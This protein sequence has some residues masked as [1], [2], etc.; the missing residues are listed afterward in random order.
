MLG[1]GLP[2]TAVPRGSVR[3]VK[4][5][6]GGSWPAVSVVLP[7]LNEEHHLRTSVG[8]ILGQSYPG[9][10]EVVIALGPSKD[11]T[12]VVANDLAADPRI[13]IV[14]NPTGR[15]PNG[16]NAAIA[17][18]RHPVIAR[19]DGHAVIPPDYLRTAVALLERTGADNVGGLMSAHGVTDIEQAVAWAMTSKLGVGNAPF[20]VGGHEGPADTVYLGVFRRTALDRVG[21]YDETFKRAQD[22]EMNFR[23]RATG[24]LVWFSPELSVSYRPRGSLKAVAKQYFHY[25]RWRRHVMRTH[26]A[27]VSLRYLAPPLAVAGAAVGTITGLV[28]LGLARPPLIAG[29]V[30]PGG[31]L[32]LVV[33][34]SLATSRNLPIRARALLPA[35]LSTMHMSW[36]T[37]F[38][39]SWRPDRPRRR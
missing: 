23:L 10:L 35:V 14:A 33:G 4:A 28:G 7:V 38:L 15:T 24:G 11:H 2:G 1:E 3:L 34:G 5:A 25:G 6:S 30:L 39:S 37:G 9:E 29:F 22:W 20:H 18:S 26:P 21:G 12:D 32:M 8:A 27:S 19:V 13:S 17:A 36:G 31:Y 16:L